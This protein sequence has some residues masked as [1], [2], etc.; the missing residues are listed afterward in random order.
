[1]RIEKTATPKADI[2]YMGGDTGETLPP[3][4]IRRKINLFSKIPRPM[5]SQRSE[6]PKIR[7]RK[8]FSQER[9]LEESSILP[10]P[11][12]SIFTPNL[13]LSKIDPPPFLLH[14]PQVLYILPDGSDIQSPLTRIAYINLTE[15]L[16]QLLSKTQQFLQNP[17]IRF[18]TLREQIREIC[19]PPEEIK[20]RLY[21]NLLLDINYKL[22]V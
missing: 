3:Q 6:L 4:V 14:D 9:P 20:L 7:E 19:K 16:E 11:K 21:E 5:A 22:Y 18:M 15:Y 8:V 1:L 2:L 13:S 10:T 17:K 12:R